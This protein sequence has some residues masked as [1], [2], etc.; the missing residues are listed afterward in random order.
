MKKL[1]G[2]FFISVLGLNLQ[3]QVGGPTT[4]RFL[5]IPM[6]ARAAALGGN[7]MSI[8]GDD[9]NLYYSN[10]ALLN[11]KCVKQVALNYCN[12]IADMNFG[13]VAYAHH[14]KNIGTVAGGIQFFDYG[15]F[16]KRDEYDIKE[17]NFKAA[18]YSLNLSIAR[19]LKDTSFSYGVTL[20][21][22]YSHYDIYNS[23]GNAVDLGL[24]WVHKSGFIASAVVKNVGVIWKPYDK[25]ND[26][27]KL[28]VTTQLGISYKVKK[29]PF[30]LIFVYDNLTKWDLTYTSPLN[31]T[32]TSNLFGETPKE[33][34]KWQKF[35]DNVKKGGDKLGRHMTFAT[36]IILTKNFNLRVGY[37]WRLH[38]EMMLPD[39][40]TASGLSFGFGFKINR[41]AL[42][43][44]YTKYNITGTSSV[45]GITTHLGAYTKK[46]KTPEIS[47]DAIAPN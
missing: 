8:W 23:V 39:K 47:P 33:K 37:N 40:R 29:A 13:N 45:I 36:E 26:T 5:E 16:D 27:T 6:P 42:S 31:E 30:R 34:T 3:S 12:Y 20:K 25:N 10:P 38:K 18:D 41:F 17:G 9:I 14:F 15:K 7:S 43:Y 24:T 46:V 2:I 28:P 32:E 21:T 4:Y 35:S 11:E 19:R 44:A 1:L 22:I